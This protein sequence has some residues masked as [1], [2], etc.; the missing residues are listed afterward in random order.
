MP[1]GFM[2]PVAPDDRVWITYGRRRSLPISATTSIII[3]V[4]L[5]GA[6]LL[7]AFTL[8]GRKPPMEVIEIEPIFLDGTPGGGAGGTDLASGRGE[9]AA[10]P[11]DATDVVASQHR[12]PVNSPNEIPPI[13]K[14]E[15]P[16]EPVSTESDIDT[17]QVV[18]DKLNNLPQVASVRP[19]LKGLLD[20]PPAKPGVGRGT[21]QG[22]G[23]GAGIGDGDGGAGR[24]S[25]KQKRQLRW[26]LL[27][28]VRSAPDYLGQLSRMKA[29]I[30]VQYP[31]KS[32]K[33]IT[34]LSERPAKLES[35]GAPDRIFWMDD[36]VDAVR[37]M[38]R[39]LAITPVPWRMIAFF[40]ET[41]EDELLRKEKAFGKRFGRESEDDFQETVFRVDD[42]Y[43]SI[44]IS[45]V[46]QTGKK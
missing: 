25:Q 38:A 30:G 9:P 16:A 2:E 43:G 44:D 33:L 3:H 35:G 41:L 5:I 15:P 37:S 31:D 4:A 22:T 28:S 19:M 21:G 23:S 12:L 14:V 6:V 11:V 13:P 26:T 18:R 17:A 45:V 39:E 8:F 46:R 40:P 27:F 24:L 32:I 7:G 36:N 42:H 29:I 20:G 10:R 34:N 1:E